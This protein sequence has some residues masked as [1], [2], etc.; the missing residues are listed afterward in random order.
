MIDSH[1]VFF[2]SSIPK[3]DL[4]KHLVI[5]TS[6]KNCAQQFDDSMSSFSCEKEYYSFSIGNDD[7]ETVFFCTEKK[8]ISLWPSGRRFYTLIRSC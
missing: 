8:T 6:E 3:A 4:A 2:F 7:M 1:L 5:K